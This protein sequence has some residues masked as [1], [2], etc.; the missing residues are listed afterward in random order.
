MPGWGR[1][2]EATPAGLS[3]FSDSF[4]LPVGSWGSQARAGYALS[5][6]SDLASEDWGGEGAVHRSL[7]SPFLFCREAPF[8]FSLKPRS[9]E[10]PLGYER[11]HAG[12]D[13]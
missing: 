13:V 9:S 12:P 11:N 6:H 10:V 1:H 8:P 7:G 5:L 3:F 2:T 4:L